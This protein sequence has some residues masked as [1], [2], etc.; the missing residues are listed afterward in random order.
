MLAL[1]P[2]TLV[3]GGSAALLLLCL[4]LCPVQVLHQRLGAL[5][6]QV[7]DGKAIELCSR[8]VMRVL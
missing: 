6:G 1:A 3:D 7:F 8:K 5:P 4:T 2:R